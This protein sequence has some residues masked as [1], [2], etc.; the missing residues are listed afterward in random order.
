MKVKSCEV[1][2]QEHKNELVLINADNDKKLISL[3]LSIEKKTF[4]SA[5]G[6]RRPLLSY[7]GELER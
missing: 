2:E 5:K 1:K 3:S 4:G 7:Y 6:H